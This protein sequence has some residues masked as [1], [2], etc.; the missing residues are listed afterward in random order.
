MLLPQDIQHIQERL[1]GE[2]PGEQAHLEMLPYREATSNMMKNVDT[3]RGSSV[4]ILL[5]HEENILKS[6]LIQRPKYNG[7]YSLNLVHH[8]WGMFSQ[9]RKNLNKPQQQNQSL[10]NRN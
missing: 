7:I 10:E 3:Y 1:R 4:A 6:V 5:Y 9:F 8:K 2:L